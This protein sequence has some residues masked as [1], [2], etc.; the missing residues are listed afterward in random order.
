GGGV[1]ISLSRAVV[2]ENAP[3]RMIA[4]VMSVYQLG[5]FGGMPLGAF[6][7]GYVVHEIGPRLSSLIP[8]A[9]LLLVLIVIALTTPILALRRVR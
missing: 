5:M 8:M 4:R 2:Q 1:G 7:M 6:V 3:P 9:G